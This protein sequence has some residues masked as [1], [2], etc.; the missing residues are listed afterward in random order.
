MNVDGWSMEW[1]RQQN[2]NSLDLWEVKKHSSKHHI[3]MEGRGFGSKWLVLCYDKHKLKMDNYYKFLFNQ[4][5]IIINVIT[6]NLIYF[7][8]S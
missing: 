2:D 6:I 3:A 7:Y 4:E 5:I 1:K 8:L